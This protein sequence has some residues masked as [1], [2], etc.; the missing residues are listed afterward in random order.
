MPSSKTLNFCTW[1]RFTSFNYRILFHRLQGVGSP[2]S[3]GTTYSGVNSVLRGN[4]FYIWLALSFLPN[5]WAPNLPT[6]NFHWVFMQLFGAN[7]NKIIL[8]TPLFPNSCYFSPLWAFISSEKT[9]SILL[10]I[11]CQ[12]FL[13]GYFLGGTS[14]TLYFIIVSVTVEALHPEQDTIPHL[15]AVFNLLQ[16]VLSFNECS[17]SLLAF[18]QDPST[19]RTDFLSTLY[20]AWEHSRNS[21]KR[22]QQHLRFIPLKGNTINLQSNAAELE[23]KSQH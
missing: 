11:L 6:R 10:T 20:K 18:H 21:Q 7:L 13:L 12:T 1:I 3:F 5:F 19:L 15:R 23:L 2:A 4:T 17:Q 8:L 22:S 16:G 14:C 9:S